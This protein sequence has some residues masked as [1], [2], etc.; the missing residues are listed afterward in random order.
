MRR[1]VKPM[2]ALL[3]MLSLMIGMCDV[4][5]RAV[6]TYEN[7]ES[8]GIIQSVGTTDYHVSLVVSN[9]GEVAIE[10]QI[11]A[12]PGCTDVQMCVCLQK[13]NA[14]TGMWTNIKTWRPKANGLYAVLNTTY[15]LLS[16]GEY[17]CMLTG[18]VTKNGK[19][20][21]IYDTSKTVV[22]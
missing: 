6:G 4:C 20:D 3:I 13:K 11:S 15:K 22:Y 14:N 9:P 1:I 17:R 19:T 5:S 18:S 16:R 21:T 8:V 2:M 7:G 10:A 12:K